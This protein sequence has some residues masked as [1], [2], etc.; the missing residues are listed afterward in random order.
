MTGP[1]TSSVAVSPAEQVGRR[2]QG[3]YRS[4]QGPR[5]QAGRRHALH[6][7]KTDRPHPGSLRRGF[8]PLGVG[9][10]LEYRSTPSP[11]PHRPGRERAP[12]RGS[13]DMS[14]T[15]RTSPCL[16]EE[17]KGV[18]QG[19]VVCSGIRSPRA[20]RRRFPAAIANPAS[21]G[22]RSAAATTASRRLGKPYSDLAPRKVYLLIGVNNLI[23]WRFARTRAA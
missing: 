16:A 13:A 6:R 15:S 14:T 1:S 17:N 23:F 19:G 7:G 21:A 18:K 4:V 3:D 9:R 12:R 10:V 22:T 5:G 2:G 8:V 20:G 11:G